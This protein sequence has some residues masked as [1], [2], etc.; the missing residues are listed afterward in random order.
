PGWR[1][2]MDSTAEQPN[3]RNL[4]PLQRLELPRKS[5][6]SQKNNIA[7]LQWVQIPDVPV[8]R[9]IALVS[10]VAVAMPEDMETGVTAA[11]GKIVLF[12]FKQLVEMNLEG[13][14]KK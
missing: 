2:D 13:N 9:L 12:D 10:T 14:A 5:E 1:D 11:N 7:C 3:T 8:N 4:R 6:A